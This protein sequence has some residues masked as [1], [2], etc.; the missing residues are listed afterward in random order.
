MSFQFMCPFIRKEELW[1]RAEDIRT[2]YLVDYKL[3]IDSELICEKAGLDVVPTAMPNVFDCCIIV[4]R[5]ELCVSLN[6]YLDDR[7][8]N[9]LRFTFAH[10]LGHFILHRSILEELSLQTIDD[11]L[12]FLDAEQDEA[13][14]RFEFQANE[15]AGRLLVPRDLLQERFEKLISSIPSDQRA[16]VADN[17]DYLKTVA[18]EKICVEFGVSPR[19]IAIRLEREG[20]WPPR[21]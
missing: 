3:P 4:S 2:T 12:E 17:L 11:Y 18:S 6:R 5:N 19:V 9:R 1:G 21:L 13:Y 10:E 14:L 8:E 20:L 15:F 16:F 7:N